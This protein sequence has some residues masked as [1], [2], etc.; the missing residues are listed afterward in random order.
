M[1]EIEDLKR[2]TERS[3]QE[4]RL[5]ELLAHLTV[6]GERVERQI[7]INW[8]GT[9]AWTF[10]WTLWIV[11]SFLDLLLKTDDTFYK[12]GVIIYMVGWSYSRWVDY[13]FGFAWKEYDATVKVLEILGIVG[14]RKPPGVK[15]KK[16][17]LQFMVDLVKSWATK[18]KISQEKVYQ[19]A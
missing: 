7:K 2:G 4:Q 5:N 14:L 13:Q 15:N 12:I 19:P 9:A 3:L 18:K 1:S 16:K 17:R 8:R 11:M 6:L 10:S